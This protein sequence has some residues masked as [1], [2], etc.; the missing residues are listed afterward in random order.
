[1]VY[2]E[3]NAKIKFKSNNFIPDNTKKR[4][5]GDYVIEQIPAE[6]NSEGIISFSFREK[7]EETNKSSLFRQT[8]LE[9]KYFLSF[10]SLISRSNCE[11]QA[12]YLDFENILAREPSYILIRRPFNFDELVQYYNKLSTL[13]KEDKRRFTNACKRYQQAI[14]IWN[15]EPVVSLF[16]F[17]V[18]IECLSNYETVQ[19]TDN[20]RA[21]YDGF[22][23][24]KVTNAVRFAE[25]V[26]KY[27]PQNL[28]EA[29]GDID[30]LKKRLLSAYFIRNWFV[31]DGDDLPSP[32]RIADYLGKKSLVYRVEKHRKRYE[33]RAPSLIW[34]EKIV[35]NTL[36]GFLNVKAGR[37]KSKPIFRHQ[38]KDAMKYNLKLR[39]T[40]PSIQKGQEITDKMLLEDFETD[41]C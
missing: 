6:G 7:P 26:C 8:Y 34:F 38:A 15:R 28:L 41:D 13:R 32:V 25:F 21:T 40:H 3:H 14:S 20:M 33:M 4:T 17:V 39:P 22:C 2:V 19:L 24:K 27:L 1:M 5:I 29:E 10:L 23:I 18:A 31:H 12:G 37:R 35:V 16:L 36:V 9:A 30:L 11:F